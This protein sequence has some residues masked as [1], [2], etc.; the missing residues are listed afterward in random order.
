MKFWPLI[1]SG[2]A[3]KPGRSV[4]IFL[5][6]CVAFALFGVLQGLQSGVERLIDQVRADVLVVHG[7]LALFDPLP[8]ALL[9]RIKSV[10]GVAVVAPVELFQA[11]YQTPDKKVGVV[12][13]RPD[14]GWLSAFTFT[15][16]PEAAVAFRRNRTAAATTC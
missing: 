12:A 3:R 10:P 9:E 16:A 11:S 2:V 8:L 1:W 6:V 15:I 14:E 13:V 5:Q 4:L 7:K